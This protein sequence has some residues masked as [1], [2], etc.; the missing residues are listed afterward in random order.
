MDNAD[1]SVIGSSKSLK[2]R[3]YSDVVTIFSDDIPVMESHFCN[4]G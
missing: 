3:R 4:L 1:F 2:E